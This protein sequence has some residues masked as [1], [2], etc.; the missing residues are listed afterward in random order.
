[1]QSSLKAQNV[2]LNFKMTVKVKVA[3]SCPTLCDP[4]DHT[5]HGTLQA[6]ILEWIAFPFS[7][8]SFQPRART[9]VSRIAGRFFTSCKG[10]HKGSPEMTVGG[11]KES[12][13]EMLSSLA[14]GIGTSSRLHLGDFSK[15]WGV[16]SRPVCW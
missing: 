4:M 16:L 9:Q 12:S 6:R 1:M 10:S 15:C 13:P 8:R 7:R 5:D 3:Q 14:S 11:F 2:K